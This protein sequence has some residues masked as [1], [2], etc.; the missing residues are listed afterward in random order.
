MPLNQPIQHL[1][2]LSAANA[3]NKLIGGKQAQNRRKRQCPRG[4]ADL[5]FP[6]PDEQPAGSVPAIGLW[7]KEE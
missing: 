1:V 5:A 6:K 2:V 3:V 7:I 4:K